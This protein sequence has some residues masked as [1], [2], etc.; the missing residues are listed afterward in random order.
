M[1]TVW[2]TQPAAN[3][4]NPQIQIEQRAVDISGGSQANDA[5]MLYYSH[6]AAARQAEASQP[7]SLL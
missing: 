6:P 5:A 3:R 1:S 2:S 7:K 4:A